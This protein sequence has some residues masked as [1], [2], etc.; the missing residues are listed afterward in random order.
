MF[1]TGSLGLGFALVGALPTDVSSPLLVLIARGNVALATVLNAV[2][3]TLAPVLVPALFLLY[4]GVELDVPVTP[5][6][7]ELALTVLV[8]TLVGVAIRTWRPA[9]V[10]PAEPALSAAASIA[11][12]LL[13][14]A[15]V[16]P[17]TASILVQ[18]TTVLAA[19]GAALALNAVG[20]LFGWAPARSWPIQRTARRCCS[21]CPRRSSA[22]P[23]SW[24]SPPGSRQRSPCP[25]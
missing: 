9:R 5:L 18:P 23:R 2:N 25:R 24:C 6:I 21:P 22:S 4:T 7:G 13:V 19:V 8:P 11:Y 15:V 12:L 20:Y 1:G 3:T 10:E 16:G 17:N 14:L